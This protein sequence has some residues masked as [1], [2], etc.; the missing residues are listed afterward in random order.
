MCETNKNPLVF[1][2]ISTC[3]ISSLKLGV[4]E[5]WKE[6]KGRAEEKDNYKK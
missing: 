2:K 4:D 1:L 5:K 6:K 3:Q